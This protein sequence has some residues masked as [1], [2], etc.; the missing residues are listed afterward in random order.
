M[1][2][3]IFRKKSKE[4]MIGKEIENNNSLTGRN[5]QQIRDIKIFIRNGWF[6][7]KIRKEWLIGREKS[8][9][10]KEIFWK[11]IVK[12]WLAGRIWIKF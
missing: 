3:K 7:G 10:E 1:E 4:V 8:E 2:L 6:A 11:R 9:K 12:E 5:Y